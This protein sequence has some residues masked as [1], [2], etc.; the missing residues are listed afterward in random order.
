MASARTPSSGSPRS[1][2]RTISPPLRD[3]IADLYDAWWDKAAER[4]RAE[5]AAAARASAGNWCAGAALDD[6]LDIPGYRPAPATSHARW[7]TEPRALLEN[8]R[9]ITRIAFPEPRR[10]GFLVGLGSLTGQRTTSTIALITLE[11]IVTR[12]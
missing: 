7:V 1:D 4:T 12:S 5:R 3:T 6:Q 8:D 10:I 9:V 11:V 2:A